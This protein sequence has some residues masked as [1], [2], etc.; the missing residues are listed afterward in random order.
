MA[1]CFFPRL[2]LLACFSLWASWCSAQTVAL[3]F[4][5]GL[6]PGKQPEAVQWNA[7]LLD[8]L[9]NQGIQSALF[10][11]L[12]RI[13]GAEG[14]ALVAEWSRAGHSVGNHTANHRSLAD[15][16]VSLAAF[17]ADVETADAA[18]RNMPTFVPMLRFPYLKEGDTPAKRDGMRVWMTKNGYRSAPVSIDASDWYYSR[19]Y[20]DHMKAGQTAKAQGVKQRYIRH[21]L[22]RA[23][24]YDGLARQVLGRSPKHVMLLHTNQLNADAL[25]DVIAALTAQGWTIAAASAAFEDPLY[26]EAPDN[27][28]AGESIVWALAKAGNLPGLRYPAEDSTYEEPLLRDAG[29]LP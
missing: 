28:P 23:A 14:L 25:P 12:I 24:Y 10:P 27:L 4:D 22:D 21:L 26:A 6:N 29:L 3:T 11:S 16:Q 2:V 18:L 20:A 17:I 7:Q 8:A 1:S 19:V 9:R 13:G 15:S 5:D